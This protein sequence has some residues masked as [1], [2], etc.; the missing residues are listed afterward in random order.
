MTMAN[1]DLNIQTE[2]VRN[3][4]YIAYRLQSSG[5]LLPM[6][7]LD[8]NVRFTMESSTSSDIKTKLGLRLL[9]I[10]NHLKI[11]DGDIP[12]GSTSAFRWKKRSDQRFFRS[13]DFYRHLY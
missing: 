2:F 13:F 5:M 8:P 3:A 10:V 6:E 11:L 9:R 7:L 4:Y 1:I 12:N